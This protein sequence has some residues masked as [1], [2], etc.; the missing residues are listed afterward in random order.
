MKTTLTKLVCEG[1]FRSDEVTKL[2]DE[3]DIIVTN[4]P[5]SMFREFLAWIGDKKFLVL[6]NK[7]AITYKE[8]F[9][10]IK[11][12]K[13][14][15]GFTGCTDMVFRLPP[16]QAITALHD[17]RKAER[18]GYVGNYICMRSC[19]WFTNLDHGRRHR[20][21]PLAETFDGYV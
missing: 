14:W 9:P 11:D 18:L 16:S 19:R 15:L 13:V 4:P 21:L 12:N 20:A 7:N 10:L 8:V 3:A 6:G 17:Q 5:F 2:R 1:D